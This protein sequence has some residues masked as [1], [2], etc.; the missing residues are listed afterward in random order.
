MTVI[1]SLDHFDQP[2][3][4]QDVVFLKG[5]TV[6]TSV[7][8]LSAGRHEWTTLPNDLRQAEIV[9]LVV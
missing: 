9:N 2:I 3:P 5:T 8:F 4:E 7:A 6:S 1:S